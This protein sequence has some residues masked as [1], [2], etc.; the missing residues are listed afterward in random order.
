MARLS[1]EAA[2]ALE[3]L[4]KCHDVPLLAQVAG[5][6]PKTLRRWL[7]GRS[8]H[9]LMLVGLLPYLNALGLE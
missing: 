9:P 6:S 7:S 2:K 4:R 8:G 3:L 5:V 1:V